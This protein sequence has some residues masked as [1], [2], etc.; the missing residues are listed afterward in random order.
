V[1]QDYSGTRKPGMTGDWVR[2]LDEFDV[3]FL[4]LD[5]HSDSELLD[6]LRSQPGWTVDY[7]DGETVLFA[8]ADD[9]WSRWM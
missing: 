1:L 6:R 3:R 9:A 7:R 2:V 4:L 8:R 5:C